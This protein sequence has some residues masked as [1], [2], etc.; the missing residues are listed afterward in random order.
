MKMVISM[1]SR[2]DRFMRDTR[3]AVTIMVVLFS[4]ALLTAAGLVIDFGRAF[5]AHSQM[6][7]YIDKVAL[8]AAQQLNGQD[9]A[10]TRAIAAANA[11]AQGSNLIKGGGGFS[12]DQIVFMTGDPVDA[13]GFFDT[14]TI[15][16]LK[17]TDPSLATH[18]IVTADPEAVRMA[19]LSLNVG[20]N[21]RSNPDEI[22]LAAF[23]VATAKR[24]I[25]GGLSTIV[26]CNPFE[27]DE[28]VSF[29]SAMAENAGYHM[30][31]VVDLDEVD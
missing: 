3:A 17:T 31:L 10:I 28:G 8:A 19:L 15:A 12:I 4:A 30:E 6:Q 16:A 29:E 7:N 18:V 1:R 14:T 26:M 13:N 2:F 20:G 21:E 9:D 5:S 24:T 27:D 25:C 11:Q 23:A 22:P